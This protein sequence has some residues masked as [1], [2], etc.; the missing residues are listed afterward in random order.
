MM[1]FLHA[2]AAL[3]TLCV[4]A[5]VTFSVS[6]DGSEAVVLRVEGVPAPLALDDAQ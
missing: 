2:R 5:I 4:F 6:G 3:A 1:R